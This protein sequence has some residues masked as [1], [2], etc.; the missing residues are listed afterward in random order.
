MC[1]RGLTSDRYVCGPNL[2]QGLGARV[3]HHAERFDSIE[4]VDEVSEAG[5]CR[6][7]PLVRPLAGS[8]EP[9]DHH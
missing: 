9:D 6:A 7:G 3:T 1:F 8:T 5:V 2:V 4:N